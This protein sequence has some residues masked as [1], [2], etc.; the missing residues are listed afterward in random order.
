[1]AL[2]LTAPA[3]A[4]KRFTGAAAPDQA[5]AYITGH[6]ADYPDDYSPGTLLIGYMQVYDGSFMSNVRFAPSLGHQ[7]V[8]GKTKS[9]DDD[10]EGGACASFQVVVEHFKDSTLDTLRRGALDAPIEINR[11]DE[12]Y[13]RMCMRSKTDFTVEIRRVSLDVAADRKAFTIPFSFSSGGGGN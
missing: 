3:E 2:A 5:G 1:M 9:H 6:L 8:V 4:A 13:G 11:S 10:L 12:L 7:V